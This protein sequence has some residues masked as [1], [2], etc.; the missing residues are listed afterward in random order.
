MSL[1]AA[2]VLKPIVLPKQGYR[3]LK[4]GYELPRKG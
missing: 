3:L 2:R 1:R 4:E